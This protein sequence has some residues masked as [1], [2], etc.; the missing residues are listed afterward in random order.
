[1]PEK[2]PPKPEPEKKP[3][4]PLPSDDHKKLWPEVIEPPEPESDF[5]LPWFLS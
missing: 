1:M 3:P 4:K 2:I 5:D